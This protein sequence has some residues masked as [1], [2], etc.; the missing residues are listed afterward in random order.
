MELSA[1]EHIPN[2]T[3][4]QKLEIC[5]AAGKSL[6]QATAYIP[7]V[8][9]SIGSLWLTEQ[10]KIII[11][12]TTHQVKNEIQLYPWFDLDTP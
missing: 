1:Q 3:Q 12:I 2:L 9:T 7:N 8:W 11:G 4:G 6:R 5:S 10:T